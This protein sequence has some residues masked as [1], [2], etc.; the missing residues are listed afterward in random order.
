MLTVLTVLG[1]RPEAIKM[2]PV[3]KELGKHATG[4]R[5]VV[6]SVGQHREMLD[7]ALRL[8]QIEPDYD[9]DLMQADQSLSQLTAALFSGLDP[10]VSTVK[11]DWILA[12][13]DT[14]TVFVAAMVAFYQGVAFGHGRPVSGRAIKSAKMKRGIPFV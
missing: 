7:Q 5:S 9:L 4:V 13:G 2:A 11:P 8:F 14:T 12:Q 3:I 10:V 6:C 1:T